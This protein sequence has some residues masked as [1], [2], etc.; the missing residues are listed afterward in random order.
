MILNLITLATVKAQ[1]GLAVTTHDTALNAMIPIVSSDVRRILNNNYD[2][3]L[4]AAYT[5]GEAT[6]TVSNPH[7][8]YMGQIIYGDSIPEDTYIKA[9]NPLTGIYTMS[10]DATDDG[11]YIYPTIQMSQWPTISKMI[12]YKTS[13]QT[14]ASAGEQKVSSES[15]GPVSKSYAES[16]IN[17]KW[18]YPQSLIDDLGTPYAR[19]G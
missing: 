11:T 18:N 1:L 5:S 12:W 14:T 13:K 17:R 7:I 9:Y 15:Y 16:E 3:C 4:G 8:L 2:N 19:I 10:V 6:L